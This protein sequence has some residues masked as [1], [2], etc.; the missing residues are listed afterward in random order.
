[1]N[2][3][4][5]LRRFSKYLCREYIV[6]SALCVTGVFIVGLGV[7]T[8]R[9]A[10]FGLDPFMCFVN[11]LYL[12]V[13]QPLGLDFGTGF[14]IFSF[15]MLLVVLVLDRG[16]I[17]LGTVATM[18]ITGYVSDLAVFLLRLF[19]P[20]GNRA[21]ILRVFCMVF[22]ILLIGAGSGIYFNTHVGVS[23][24]DAAGLI[25]TKKTGRQNWY[26]WI[27]I[28]TDTIF[29]VS[30]FLLGNIPGPGTVIMA[31]FT[32]PIFAFFRSRFLVWGKRQRIITW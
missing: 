22:G 21:L 16:E 9:F 23:P 3:A 20:E 31:F 6:K 15:A 27:R 28:G 10:D 19:P 4:I 18:T 25:I 17:G 7:G 32:G 8:L 2:R 14:V 29:V 26:R 30:G 13:F 1:M 12:V 11:G 24:Y 5:R